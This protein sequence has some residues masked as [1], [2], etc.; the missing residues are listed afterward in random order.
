MNFKQTKEM[1]QLII[2]FIFQ[3]DSNQALVQSVDFTFENIIIM[4][5][6]IR[7]RRPQFMQY[8]TSTK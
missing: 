1:R 2:R 7:G 5:M 6:L 3:A 8:F 4:A